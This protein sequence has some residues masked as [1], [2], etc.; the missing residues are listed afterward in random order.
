[1]SVRSYAILRPITPVLLTYRFV[2]LR[3]C[4]A[5]GAAGHSS[6]ALVLRTS[7]IVCL[8]SSDG[9]IRHLPIHQVTSIKSLWSSVYIQRLPA[10]LSEPP[11]FRRLLYCHLPLLAAPASAVARE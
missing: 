9:R 8:D 6:T 1:M 10:V 3:F 11:K 4:L 5:R 2:C 7:A